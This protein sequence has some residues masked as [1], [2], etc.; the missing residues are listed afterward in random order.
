MWIVNGRIRLAIEEGE[1]F[2]LAVGIGNALRF[3]QGDI[4]RILVRIRR[5]WICCPR[6]ALRFGNKLEEDVG[7]LRGLCL[8]CLAQTFGA[9]RFGFRIGMNAK[10]PLLLENG[11][12]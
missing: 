11:G 5:T 4:E 1:L 7:F 6:G 9:F 2:A 3:G 10:I 8:L 12:P